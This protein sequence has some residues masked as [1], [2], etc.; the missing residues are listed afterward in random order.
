MSRDSKPRRRSIKLIVV[1]ALVFGAL[2]YCG[3][4]YYMIVFA[5]I[6]VANATNAHALS[7]LALRDLSSESQDQLAELFDFYCSRLTGDESGEFV[8]DDS[9]SLEAPESIRGVVGSVLSATDSRTLTWAENRVRPPYARIDYVVVPTPERAS[10]YVVSA[11]IKP[12]PALEKRWQGRQIAV[13]RGETRSSNVE[14][15]I[16]ALVMQWFVS[17][18]RRYDATPDEKKKEYLDATARELIAFQG[19]YNRF[20]VS[21]GSPELSL[22]E[23]LREFERTNEGWC[24]ITPLD[25]LARVMWFKDLL[26]S[27]VVLQRANIDL[28]LYPPTVAVKGDKESGTA[29]GS[30]VNSAVKA[31]RRALRKY[32]FEGDHRRSIA[33]D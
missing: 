32:F 15:N 20:R 29:A 12:G 9:V 23:L 26:V 18:L 16:R 6:N 27:I 2:G 22:V 33:S 8:F 13:A 30:R 28:P 25:E 7:W 31:T 17:R 24:E 4:Q 10:R 21:N 14:R 1:L 3:W 11:D 5:P 19:F